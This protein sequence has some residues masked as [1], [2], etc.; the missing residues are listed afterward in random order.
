[1]NFVVMCISNTIANAGALQMAPRRNRDDPVREPV[2]QALV[3]ALPNKDRITEYYTD[4]GQA[5][6]AAQQLAV[7]NPTKQYA[8]LGTMRVYE[9]TTPKVLV[10]VYNDANEL[11]LDSK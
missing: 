4:E 5:N 2:A 1:M 3:L 6:Q 11:V 10:K 7:Q 9:T 8:V